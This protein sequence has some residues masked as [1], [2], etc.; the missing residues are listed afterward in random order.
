MISQQIRNTENAKSDSEHHA[1]P[2]SQHKTTIN[3]LPEGQHTSF[4]KRS[5]NRGAEDSLYSFDQTLV[6]TG[7]KSNGTPGNPWYN[8]SH[9]HGHSSK[10]NSD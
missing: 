3:C 10:C 1:N 4:P 7:N 2:Q 8:F 6:N 9:S 5:D